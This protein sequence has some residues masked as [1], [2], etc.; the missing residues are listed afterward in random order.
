[1]NGVLWAAV[2]ARAGTAAEPVRQPSHEASC[3][4]MLAA[5]AVHRLALVSNG[6]AL[7]A[8]GVVRVWL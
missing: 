7:D 2:E 5:Q 4:G 1:M 6:P 3:D 8:H